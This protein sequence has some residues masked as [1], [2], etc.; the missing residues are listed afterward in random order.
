M[1]LVARYNMAKGGGQPAASVV[2][3]DT[4]SRRARFRVAT[5]AEGY[6]LSFDVHH[7]N[8]RKAAEAIFADQCRIN[9]PDGR[10]NRK[11]ELKTA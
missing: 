8:S 11:A 9:D 10:R 4:G 3:H 6:G 2:M 5:I 1:K 7:V